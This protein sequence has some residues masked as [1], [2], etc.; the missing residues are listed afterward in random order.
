M[1]FNKFID[2]ERADP[3]RDHK[4]FIGSIEVVNEE[5]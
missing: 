5:E 4:L 1:V 3:K 2:W